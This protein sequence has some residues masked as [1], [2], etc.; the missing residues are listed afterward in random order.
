MAYITLYTLQSSSVKKRCGSNGDKV[1]EFLYSSLKNTHRMLLDARVVDCNN[2]PNDFID[3][4]SNTSR[5][6]LGAIFAGY[7]PLVSQNPYPIIVYSV[8]DPIL[9][10]FE[11]MIFSLE[12]KVPKTCNLISSSSILKMP[13]RR[14]YNSQS[15]RENSTQSSGAT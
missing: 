14:S 10:T 4:S 2:K 12:L 8:K 5:E 11:Q 15:S 7:V 13:E 3:G 6:I 9:V 1:F